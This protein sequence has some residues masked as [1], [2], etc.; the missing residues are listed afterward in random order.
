MEKGGS[1]QGRLAGLAGC[2][3]AHG[4]GGLKDNPLAS[5]RT[6]GSA[7]EIVLKPVQRTILDL[8]GSVQPKSRPESFGDI[9]R[10]VAGARSRSRVESQIG[11]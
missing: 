8:E 5:A 9:R 4:E 7:P 11:P 2:R 1:A 6:I 10:Q 3:T